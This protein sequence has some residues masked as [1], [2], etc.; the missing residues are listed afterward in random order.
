MSEEPSIVDRPATPYV[1]ITA[2]VTMDDLG[3]VVPPLTAEVFDWLRSKGIPPVGAPFWRYD[4]IDMDGGL[5]VESGVA[6]AEP[7]EGDA[8]VHAAELP[9][10][11]Y[12][13]VM[14]VGHPQT[15]RE[16]TARLLEWGSARGL[17]WDAAATADGERWGC[18]LEIYHSDPGQDMDA[19]ETELAFRL[20]D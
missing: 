14:H 4:V 12:A 15:L 17:R 6:V 19:W 11:R 20:A 8:R 16:A 2:N 9:D 3:V 7:I 5:Q 13:S 18:R 10:G 1:A